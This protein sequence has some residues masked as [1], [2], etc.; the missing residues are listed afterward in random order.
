M[1]AGIEIP[2]FS[3]TLDELQRE[4]V[5]VS[6]PTE[7][8][9]LS[10]AKSGS[11]QNSLSQ[12]MNELAAN[13]RRERKVLDLEISNS[14]LLA[15]NRQL[16]RE[17]RKQKTEL[18]RFRRLSRA[19]R[20]SSGPDRS[21]NGGESESGGGVAVTGLWDISDDSREE[22]EDHDVHDVSDEGSVDDD[23]DDDTGLSPDA[24]ADSD[25][26]HREK[27]EKRLRLDLSKHRQLLV[28]SQKMN[29]SLKRC[30]GWT[31]ELIKEGKKAL[32]YEVRVS[33]VELGGRVLMPEDQAE[34]GGNNHVDEVGE[35]GGG[36]LR[37][38]RPP[39]APERTDAQEFGP[40][41][42]E[43]IE[44]LDE[45]PSTELVRSGLT[46]VMSGPSSG[47]GDTI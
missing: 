23:D 13:A 26:R 6:S 40:L 3:R 2:V 37:A 35:R 33:D 21:S 11:G 16:E 39:S 25:A 9:P 10:P 41:T 42:V 24:L 1:L 27:D 28:D 32:D 7:V 17:V 14:S 43:R 44:E 46:G 5:I 12:E 31:E 18:R 22:Y 36:L 4:S 20:F 29:Q 47:F 30:L 38:W 45:A 19:G 34:D 15:I 8:L